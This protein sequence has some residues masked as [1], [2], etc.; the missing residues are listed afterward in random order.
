MLIAHIFKFTILEWGVRRC[1]LT[2][3]SWSQHLQLHKGGSTVGGG[4]PRHR[5]VALFP[6]LRNC[7]AAGEPASAQ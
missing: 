3:G 2:A 7:I 1:L 5:T 6:F 4:S